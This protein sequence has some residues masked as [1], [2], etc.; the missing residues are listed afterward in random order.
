LAKQYDFEGLPAIIMFKDGEK[1]PEYH[2]EGCPS[3]S[4]EKLIEYVEAALSM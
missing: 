3:D 1:V 2:F 4:K